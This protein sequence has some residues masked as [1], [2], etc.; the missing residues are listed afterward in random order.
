V[1]Y[2]IC[3]GEIGGIA[4][5]DNMAQQM[6]KPSTEAAMFNNNHR[7]WIMKAILSLIIATSLSL[8]LATAIAAGN[9]IAQPRATMAVS[10]VISQMR[11]GVIFVRT[12]WGQRTPPTSDLRDAKVGDEVLLL[13][14]TNNT[15]IDAHKKT[16]VEV[17]K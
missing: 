9:D 3:T 10:G 14:D 13:V 1:T 8:P 5:P 16:V 6:L 17:H 7:R 2:A 4:F 15:V 11:S 12:P